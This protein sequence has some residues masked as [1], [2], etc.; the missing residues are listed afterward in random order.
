MN[1]ES[2]RQ[3]FPDLLDPRRGGAAVPSPDPQLEAARSHLADC[4]ACQREFAGLSSALAAL[5]AL[6][7]PPPTPRLRRDFYAMLEEEKHSAASVR[8]EGT[9]QAQRRRTFV[10]RWVIAPLA[11]CT[12]ALAGFLGG[13]EYAA[14]ARPAAAADPAARRELQTLQ[15]KV[16][17]METMNRLVAAALQQQQQPATYRLQHVVATSN[18]VKPGAQVI[19]AL[20]TSLALDT[21]ANVRLRALEALYPHAGNPVVREGVLTLLPREPNA[22]VQVAMIDFL[23]AAR[24]GAARPALER[25]SANQD[26]DKNVR[27]AATRAL[28][29]L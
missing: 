19:D 20:L 8:F 3:S 23:A 11:G 16:D 10:W 28:A 6:P 24:D 21:S 29:Q 15:A 1:C 4:P 27:T 2:A 14:P 7:V 17:R 5:D 13:L 22:L 26:A 12:L 9:R 25:M 18:T